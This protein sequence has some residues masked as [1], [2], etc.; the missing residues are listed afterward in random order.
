MTPR[1]AADALA[2]TGDPSLLATE[3]VA[4]RLATDPVHGLAEDEATH[5]L[6][7]DGPNELF[8]PPPPARW[9]R[10][11]AQFHD[12]LVHL[13]LAAAAITLLVWIVEG[14]HGLPVDA[15]VILAV[16]LA[17]A[18]IGFLQET[19]SG[20]AAAALAR[21]SAQRSTV[22]RAGR[23]QRIASAALVRGDLLVLAEGD[24]VG[25]DARLV[26]ASALRVQEAALTG[27]S[28][29]VAK[30]PATLATA[31]A[32]AERSNMV[33]RG[34]A[35]SQ[36]TATAIVTAT[37]MATE[38]GAIAHLLA[39]TAEDP[40]PLQR[41]VRTIG[42]RLAQAV[43]A[44]ALAVIG[45]VLAL[46]GVDDGAGLLG[47]LMLGVCLAVAAVPE[48][49]PAILSV[50]LAIGVERMAKRHAIVKKLAAVE[51][52]GSASVI[53][54]DKTGTLTRCEMTIR[55]AI[56]ASGSTRIGGAGYAPHGRMARDDGG[57]VEG[58]LRTELVALFSG[59][60]LAGNA[61]LQE[62]AP[63][64]WEIHGDPTD[65]A[66]LVA[67]RKLGVHDWRAR[68]FAT[69]AGIPF[70]AERRMMSVVVGDRERGGARW[71]VCKGAPDVLLQH[72]TQLLEGEAVRPL[73]AS[74]RAR[75][76]AATEG[77]ADE[78]LRTLAVAC[79][80]LADEESSEAG[81]ALEHELMFIGIVGIVDPPRE[82]AHEAIRE[83]QGAGIRVVMI[84]GD[85]PRTALRIARDLGIAGDD[86]TVLTARELDAMDGTQFAAA[87]ATTP[88]YARVSPAHKLRIVDALQAAGHV[89]AMTGDGIND[90][91]AL[92]SADIGIAMGRGGT[93]VAREA[94][95]MILA[96]DN[97]ATIVAAVREGRIVFDNIRTFLRYLLS[98][99]IGEIL[100][101][102]LG[103]L[104]AAVIGLGTGDGGVVLPLLATQILW[105]NLVTDTGPALAMGID[106]PGE[107]V[108]RRAPRP[109]TQRVID[110]PMWSR[111]LQT[112][113]VMALATLLAIDLHLPGGLVD[114]DGTLQ[115]ARTAGFT[116]LV[117]AQLFN[118]FNTRSATASALSGLFTNR[119]LWS[120]VALAAVLQVAV[121]QSVAGNIAFDTVPLAPGEWLTC[122]ALAAAVLLHG[123]ARKLLQRALAARRPR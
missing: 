49:L 33:F 9:R 99:N 18:T 44:I 118:C 107:D 123:E 98:S 120:S 88:V 17:N 114:G 11:L 46:H 100:T 94:A 13:L 76:L 27:E 71:L 55:H 93:E 39:T 14:R 56:T 54:S 122:A 119:W 91:P 116:T 42:R 72:C 24:R 38:M 112:G 31:C 61:G 110:A 115:R 83:A 4:A 63:G 75:L 59:G 48:G 52:L 53:C 70:T 45:S 96:D 47:V 121:V 84:T 79:R 89:V 32:L 73:E 5:R 29:T 67:E 74:R 36:G 22:I 85:H 111:V 3:E 58:A 35:V 30:D 86:A 57:P 82:E 87:V 23:R 68:R 25:A 1:S 15:L 109:P 60:S 34:T 80:P 113:L 7:V 90:G 104:G 20:R 102:L 103:I 108:M 62:A 43:I 77:L 97:F 28:D 6:R 95:R 92:K 41:E 37:G 117:F 21:L 66:F 40:T 51:A 105:I 69:L 16:V 26:E 106:P 12:P 19:R 65:A 2:S 10:F 8:T 101:V 81:S 64:R 50:V 78:A